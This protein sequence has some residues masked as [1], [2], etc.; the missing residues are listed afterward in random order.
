MNGV[1]LR[2]RVAR[3]RAEERLQFVNGVLVWLLVAVAGGLLAGLV[4][5]GAV[6]ISMSGGI[7]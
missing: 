2:E 3:R 7:R 1:T 5:S 6:L 4:A